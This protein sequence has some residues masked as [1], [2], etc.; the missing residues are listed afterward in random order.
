MKIK[1][2]ILHEFYNEELEMLDSDVVIHEHILD[3][4]KP[5]ER[6][7]MRAKS[8]YIFYKVASITVLPIAIIS[9]F[10]TLCVLHTLSDIVARQAVSINSSLCYLGI[11]L[12][13]ICSNMYYKYDALVEDF[14]SDEVKA[15]EEQNA[16]LED[17]YNNNQE[18]P[19]TERPLVDVIAELMTFP[20]NIVYPLLI[21]VIEKYQEKYGEEVVKQL[22]GYIARDKND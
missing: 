8:L 11:I 5:N 14:F 6:K 7:I 4:T 17:K 1:K 20:T 9:L 21:K 13:Y 10:V 2:A 16:A 19:T 18:E 15:V 22:G 12:N 3:K